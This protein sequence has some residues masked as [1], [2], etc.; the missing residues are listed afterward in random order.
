M[1]SPSPLLVTGASGNLG[2]R[3]VEL[4]LER[5][6]G[7]LIATTRSPAKL[8]RLQERGVEV[9]QADFNAEDSLVPAFRGAERALLVSTDELMEPGK[10][11]RQQIAAVRALAAAG[12]KHVVYTSLPNAERSSASIAPDHAATEAAIRESGLSYTILRNNLYTDLLLFTLPHALRSGALVDARGDG[13]IAHVTREDCARSAAFAL[14]ERSATGRDIYDVTGPEAIT[15]DELAA[16]V[17]EV[18]GQALK[19]VSVPRDALV[20][21]MI[22]HGMPR[23]SAELYAS[24]DVSSANGEL[25]TVTNTVERLT[26]SPPMSVREFLKA[27]RAALAG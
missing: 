1:S 3:V 27:N 20:A 14:A 13:K 2:V 4:L 5:N 8:S 24:F 10:R 17:S 16:I 21:G 25:A 7:R 11:M 15:A 26:G 6:A 18:T 9:R 22:E 19:H 12:V 23:I